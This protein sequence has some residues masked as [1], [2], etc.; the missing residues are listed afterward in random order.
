MAQQKARRLSSAEVSAR[1]ALMSLAKAVLVLFQTALFGGTWFLFYAGRLSPSPAD[2]RHWGLIAAY[3]VLFKVLAGVYGGF[4][5][6]NSS[7]PEI[8]YSL[9]VAQFLT[10]FFEYLLLCLAAC[11]LMNPL[12]LLGLLAAGC[13]VNL[14]WALAA[15]RLSRALFPPRRTYII[16]DRPEVCWEI[17]DV[18]KIRRKFLIRGELDISDGVQ[19]VFRRLEDGE[20]E[21][22]FLCGLHSSD[23]NTVLKYCVERN[24]QVYIR[25]KIGDLLVSGSTQLQLSNVPVLHCGRNRTS[26]LYLGIKRG[27]DILLSG[28]T[29]VVFSPVMAGVALAIRLYDGG[30]AFYRQTRLTKDGRRFDI[31]KFRSMRVDAEKD[32]VAR[33]AAEG[34]DR[35]TP[36]GRFIRKVR[37]D[38]LPQLLNILK[39]DMSLV[40]PRPER[41]EIAAQYE[42][43]MPEF[44]LRLQA[45][46]GLTGYAQIYGKYN[47]RPYEK[48][49]MDLIYI[50]NQ[51]VAQDLKLLF[52]TVKILFMPES[53][54]GVQEGQVTAAE[55]VVRPAEGRREALKK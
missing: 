9:G 1:N 45:K 48:L 47:T 26:L 39:G 3:L 11:R 31:L 24:I 2:I 20:A 8:V 49:Q 4:Q 55:P 18:K 10:L 36:V 17:D 14:L 12:A 52:A 22:V 23:R 53:T 29:L 25:P 40:G 38:E 6:G 19:E 16:Y 5:A 34:D 28:V 42:A 13:L 51:S 30:P 27:L 7:V 32:G 54:E 15:D 46:A 44:S 43:E 41:P 37:L 50:A 33:L 21:A 35:I